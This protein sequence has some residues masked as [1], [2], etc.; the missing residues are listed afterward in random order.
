MTYLNRYARLIAIASGIVT[1]IIFQTTL[2][3]VGISWFFTA[4]LG[5]GVYFA[6]DKVLSSEPEVKKLNKPPTLKV[7]ILTDEHE[8]KEMM[9]DAYEDLIQIQKGYRRAKHESIKINGEKLFHT[10]VAIFEHLRKNPSKIRQARRYLTYYL[11]TAAGIMNKYIGFVETRLDSEE[12][13]KVYLETEKALEILNEAFNKQFVKL[14][15][16]EM[17]DIEADVKVLEDTLRTEE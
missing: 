4:A 11:D 6:V 5:Y 12:I 16:N 10:G 8:L 9:N 7:G 2:A 1:F 17:M 15:Q 13:D 14:M 3:A